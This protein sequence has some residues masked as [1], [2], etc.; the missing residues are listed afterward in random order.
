MNTLISGCTSSVLAVYIKPQVLGTFSFVSRYDCVASGGG[1]LAGL[2]AVSG[3]CD[4]L[5][6]YGAFIIG[7]VSSL[8]YVGSC[9]L[10][11][12]LHIDDPVEVVPTYLFCGIWGTLATALFDNENGLFYNGPHKWRYFGVQVLGIVTIC[13]WTA[14]V[15]TLYFLLMKYL[16]KFRIDKS[17]EIIGLDIAEMGGLSEEF[18]DKIW[19]DT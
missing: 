18:F 3:S 2:V 7:I 4:Q 17:I 8:V 10:M 11:D 14:T 15:S 1:F 19:K 13:I 9:K 16:N 5:E 6:P 12:I